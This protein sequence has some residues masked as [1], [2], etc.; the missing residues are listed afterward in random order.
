[1]PHKR[2]L[3]SIVPG[4]NV[5]LSAVENGETNETIQSTIEWPSVHTP[6]SMEMISK[7]HGLG[8]F[9]AYMSSKDPKSRMQSPEFSVRKNYN[10]RTDDY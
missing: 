8:D 2:V 4:L 10:P 6:I 5:L 1:L 3:D 9:P 7:I